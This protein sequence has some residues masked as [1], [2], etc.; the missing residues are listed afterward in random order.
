MA[1]KNEESNIL[2]TIANKVDLFV[3]A[4]AN[5]ITFGGM[6]Y[7]AGIADHYIYDT[8][9]PPKNGAPSTLQNKIAQ[10]LNRTSEADELTSI[11]GGLIGGLA[12]GAVG[13]S[14]IAG[15][16]IWR[17]AVTS[18]S[19][20]GVTDA[21]LARD[22]AEIAYKHGSTKNLT[23][24]GD[25]FSEANTAYI[26]ALDATS[27]AN[28]A[29]LINTAAMAGGVTGSIIGNTEGKKALNEMLKNATDIETPP[30]GRPN[31]PEKPKDTSAGTKGR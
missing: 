5:G 3:R 9:G 16:S 7:L 8:S 6:D 24:L 23:A 18:F 10:Q 13:G 26:Q 4:V 28:L 14:V 2:G 21:K 19:I 27:G 29:F 17:S 25:R 11:A 1:D 15:Q 30:E 31:V 22:I 12:A 20:T